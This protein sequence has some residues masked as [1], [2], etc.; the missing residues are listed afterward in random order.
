MCQRSTPPTGREMNSPGPVSPESPLLFPIKT[1]L[2]LCTLFS[3]FP[4][5]LGDFVTN[6]LLAGHKRKKKI[7]GLKFHRLGRE[8]CLSS[9]FIWLYCVAEE[10]SRT[11][12]FSLFRVTSVFSLI[13][14]MLQSSLNIFVQLSQ[15]TIVILIILMWWIQIKCEFEH[16]LIHYQ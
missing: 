16:T 3:F 1:F 9:A 13:G 8:N 2:S 6:L 12:W 5:G 15:Q 14:K 11:C 4:G 10:Y 7:C